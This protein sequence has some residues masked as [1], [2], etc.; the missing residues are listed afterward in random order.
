VFLGSVTPINLDF[1][2]DYWLDITVGGEQMPSRLKFTSVGYA[3]RAMFADTAYA[4]VSGAGSH[5]SVSDSVLYTNKN[6]GIARGGAGNVLYGDETYS[7]VNL[8]VACTT[9]GSGLNE[10]YCTVGGGKGNTDSYIYATVGG[11]FHN[12]ASQAYVTVAGGV[13]N[14]ADAN[15]ASVGGGSANSASHGYVTVGGGS[16]NTASGFY[17]TVGG[18]YH[19][20]TSGK[21]ATVPGGYYNTASGNFS[22]AAGRKA[23]ANHVGTFVWADSSIDADFASTGNNQFLI[24]ASGGV[25]IG[26]TSP[27]ERLQVENSESGGRSFLQIEASHASNWGEAGMRIKTAQNTWH[28]RM[29]DDSNNNIPDGALGLRSQDLGG[30]VMVWTEDGKVGIGTTSPQGKLDVSSTTGAFIVPRMTT[31]QRNALSAVNGMIVYNTTT[32]QFNF[33]ENGA[34]VTK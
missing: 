16:N 32:N 13:N 12:T 7:H 5:W 27:D 31:T 18:G 28:L 20:T 14:I 3:Y 26:T 25:G 24:R 9:G 30:E 21:Y 33:H 17:A 8:G 4:T 15:Y 19:Q 2:E 23:I 1:S 29:D 22:F 10:G 34:W 6:W 11:G